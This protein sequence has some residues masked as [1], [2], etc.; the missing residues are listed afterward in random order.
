MIYIRPAASLE[1]TMSDEHYF[2]PGDRVRAMHAVGS[3][4][5]G[6]RG[7]VAYTFLLAPLYQVCFD[8]DEIPYLVAHEKLAPDLPDSTSAS[9]AS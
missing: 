6:T 2:C 1:T 3:I 7:T 5:P 8:G 4:V 9:D